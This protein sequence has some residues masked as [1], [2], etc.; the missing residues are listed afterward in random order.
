MFSC[1]LFGKFILSSSSLNLSE[2]NLPEE[3]LPQYFNAFP[4]L[5]EECELDDNCPF[6]KYLNTKK[7]WGY[8]N[9]CSMENSYSVPSC[10][11]DHKGWVSTKKA[12]FDTFFAQADFGICILNYPMLVLYF[13][14][15]PFSNQSCIIL[16]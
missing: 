4:K 12:Q 16:Y 3:H 1:S 8:E 13:I 7:C 5:A 9:Y 10:P 14:Y 6:K 11:G 2:I 15:C